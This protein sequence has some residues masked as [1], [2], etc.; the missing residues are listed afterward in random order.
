VEVASRVAVGGRVS[1]G[2]LVGGTVRVDVAV[3]VSVPVAV[4]VRVKLAVRVGGMVRDGVTVRVAGRGVGVRVP[5]PGRVAVGRG[6]GDRRHE[7]SAPPS[8][9]NTAFQFTVLPGAAGA[10][11][12]RAIASAVIIAVRMSALFIPMLA[13]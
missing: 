13:P 10:G 1:V 6:K 7:S 11:A 3:P 9:F 5:L 4:A 2:V 8:A 12:A